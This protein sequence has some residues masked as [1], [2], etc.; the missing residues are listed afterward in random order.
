MSFSSLGLPFLKQKKFPRVAKPMEEKSYGMSSED[1]LEEYCIDEL[2]E[3]VSKKDVS[4][5]RKGLEALVINSFEIGEP[6]AA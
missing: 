2:M 3:A 1:N 5:F 6:D 4:A